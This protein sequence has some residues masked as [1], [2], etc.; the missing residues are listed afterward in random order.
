MANIAD[1]IVKIEVTDDD[2]NIGKIEEICNAL[3]ELSYGYYDLEYSDECIAEIF[4]GVPW[5]APLEKL[6]NLCN[7]YG[8][9][10]IGVAYDFGVNYVD[11][12]ELFDETPI[13]ES[14]H[15][16]QME[17][18]DNPADQIILNDDENLLD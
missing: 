11:S 17:A 7:T 18:S 15:F 9:S 13:E 6:Q 1:I 14:N 5:S 4:M 12:F 8:C 3:H 10:I 16:I 2:S